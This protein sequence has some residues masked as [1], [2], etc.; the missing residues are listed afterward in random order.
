[1]CVDGEIEVPAWGIKF[2][3]VA[4]S[5]AEGHRPALKCSS[6]HHNAA[7]SASP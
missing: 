7:C 1:M 3:D 6:Q 2:D 4:N 5:T